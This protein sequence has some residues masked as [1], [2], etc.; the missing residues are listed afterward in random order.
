M[1]QIHQTFM[2]LETGIPS[3]CREIFLYT[4]SSTLL[5]KLA[6]K[7]AIFRHQNIRIRKDGYVLE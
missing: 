2:S 3:S 7:L 5:I 6:N 4:F 1:Q